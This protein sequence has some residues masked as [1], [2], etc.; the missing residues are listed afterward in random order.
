GP[1][2]GQTV[3]HVHI[4]IIPRRAGDFAVNDQAYEDLD[5]KEAEL[6]KAMSAPPPTK[7]KAKAAVPDAEED[8]KP[9]SEA[10]MAVEA[11]RLR[12]PFPECDF[13]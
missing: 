9:H 4:H 7:A 13:T 8:R 1:N 2:A 3:P 10:E 6:A 11:A 12:R 5:G